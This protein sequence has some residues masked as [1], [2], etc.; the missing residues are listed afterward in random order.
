VQFVNILAI[1]VSIDVSS[2]G[3]RISGACFM[4]SHFMT[5]KG[6]PGAAHGDQ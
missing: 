2:F 5:F 4:K 1:H 6:I 3:R